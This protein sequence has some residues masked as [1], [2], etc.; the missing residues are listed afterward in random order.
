MIG[1]GELEGKEVVEDAGLAARLGRWRKDQW[2]RCCFHFNMEGVIE[3][4]MDG[5]VGGLKGKA[6]GNG[7]GGE[8]EC[9]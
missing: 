7:G 4:G 1:R 2:F 9:C 3:A 5:I 8:G 6:E